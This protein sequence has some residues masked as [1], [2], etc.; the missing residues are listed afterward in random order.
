MMTVADQV[1]QWWLETLLFKQKI[2]PD[3]TPRHE[4]WSNNVL[5]DMAF[6]K[7]HSIEFD[8]A[9]KFDGGEDTLFFQ[10][11]TSK[12]AKGVFA[13]NAI[14]YEEQPKDRLTWNWA[15][16]RQFRNG[17]TRAMIAY[18]TKPFAKAVLSSV[19]RAGGC[20]IFGIAHVPS[21][22]VKGKVGFANAITYFA[23]C[24]GIL[25]GMLGKTFLE[26]N[27]G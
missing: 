17:N 14:V 2:F 12:G 1:D 23:R 21:I 24:F 20:F 3:G 18:K 13:A 10:T 27:R 6:V 4:A 19:I 26:Y 9:L 15:I 5:I 7:E 25:Y 16:K 8:P 11:M 22:I